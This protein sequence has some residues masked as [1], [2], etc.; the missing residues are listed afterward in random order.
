[1]GNFDALSAQEW[2]NRLLPW[3]L[4]APDAES[5]AGTCL[6]KGLGVWCQLIG[7]SNCNFQLIHGLGRESSKW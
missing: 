1:M 5:P 4:T 6:E 7:K 3:A 2:Y